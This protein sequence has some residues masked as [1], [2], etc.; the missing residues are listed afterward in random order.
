VA[1]KIGCCGFTEAHHKYFDHFDVVELQNT[2]YQPASFSAAKKWQGA[3]PSG[4]EFTV[5]AWQLITHKASSPSYKRLKNQI[6]HRLKPR[7]GNFLP[8]KEVLH[9][10]QILE[11]FATALNAKYIVFQCP[12]YFKPTK[13]NLQN[14]YK[15][16]KLINRGKFK[17]VFETQ[18]NWEEVVLQRTCDE[19]GLI[20]AADPLETTIGKGDIQY[21]R[22]QG[23]RGRRYRYT[24]KDLL[25]IKEMC[26]DYKEV[27]C[28]FNNATMRDDAQ[29]LKRLI[30]SQPV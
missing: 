24:D 3:A 5:K 7:Y 29:R 10:W 25:K 21:F 27:L 16:F 30:E 26:L 6:P 1:I 14:M 22:L 9:A 15:F 2:F 4:F 11:N 18:G 20:H 17:L 28:L 13:E 23:I 8:T 12:N 19:L